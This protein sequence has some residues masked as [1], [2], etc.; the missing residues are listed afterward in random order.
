MIFHH[1]IK[2]DELEL[3][4]IFEGQL[5]VFQ[6]LT[7]EKCGEVQWLKH[8]RWNPETYSEDMIE[9]D[10]VNKSVKLKEVLPEGDNVN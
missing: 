4:P 6:K 7:C 10:E 9:V 5:P 3:I 8:S 2:C 1:C